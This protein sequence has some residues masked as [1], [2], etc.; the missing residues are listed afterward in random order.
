[1]KTEEKSAA[2]EIIRAAAADLGID[3][4]DRESQA[5]LVGYLAGMV[6]KLSDDK[7]RLDWLEANSADL[8]EIHGTWYVYEDRGHAA[9]GIRDAIDARKA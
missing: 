4:I 3:P 8:Y 9:P 5:Q 6:V 2:F 7:A 1:M